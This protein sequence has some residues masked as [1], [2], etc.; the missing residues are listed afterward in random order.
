MRTYVRDRRS[1][2]S[3]AL[4]ECFVVEDAPAGVEAARRAGMTCVGVD[5]SG[6]ANELRASGAYI[7]LDRLDRLPPAEFLGRL[8]GRH[9]STVV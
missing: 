6:D 2:C 4:P 5:R 8:E 7:V 1:S 3:G 9:D